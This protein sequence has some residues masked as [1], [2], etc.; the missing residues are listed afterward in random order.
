V[1]SVA[2]AAPAAAQSSSGAS[3]PAGADVKTGDLTYYTVGMGACGEDDTGKDETENI[4]ALSHLLMGTVSN[5]NP[6]CG[7][8]I[9]ISSGGKTVVATVKDKCMGC[10][11]D[12]ID[13]K[14]N[15]P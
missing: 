5:G 8:T 15:R 14:P 4:V 3:S 6:M 2:D 13:G 10:A 9:T 11:I 12:A 7:K 1:A